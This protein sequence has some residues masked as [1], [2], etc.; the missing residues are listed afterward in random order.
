MAQKV[1]NKFIS[2]Y[3]ASDLAWH[4]R[5]ELDTWYLQGKSSGFL[6]NT[7]EHFKSIN[8]VNFDLINNELSKEQIK[9][10]QFIDHQEIN[11]YPRN[12]KQEISSSLFRNVK[13]KGMYV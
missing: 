1:D 5:D 10:Y 9:Q 6:N 3:I 2:K 8:I 13:R 11:K 7:D 12:L 4:E